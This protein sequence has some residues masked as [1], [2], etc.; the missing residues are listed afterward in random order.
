MTEGIAIEDLT[1][2]RVQAVIADLARLRMTVFAAFPY[3]Y[4]GDP[5]YEEDYLRG[6]IAARDAIVV[7]A[8]DGE[9]IV[10]VATA[11]PLAAQGGEIR[12]PVAAAGFA[13]ESAFYFG[14]S[15]LLDAYRGRGIGHAFFDRREA[16]ARRCG[17]RFACFASVIRPEDHPAR[18]AGYRSLEGFWR[19][20]GYAPV[21][22]LR[23]EMAW[24]E[25][26]EPGESAKALQVWM[27]DLG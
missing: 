15:V 23:I 10:G 26:G 12:D 17:A 14:E 4:D 19:K 2:A 11:S 1:G 18:P 21:P 6:F 24:K 13:P 27:R 20:R 3:L 22:G 16:Q 8:R 5:A 7:A 9:R 25:H